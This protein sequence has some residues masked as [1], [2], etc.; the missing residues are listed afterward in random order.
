MQWTPI[1]EKIFGLT[2]GGFGGTEQAFF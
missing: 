2:P 1:L